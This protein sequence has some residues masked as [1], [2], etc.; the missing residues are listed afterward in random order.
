MSARVPLASR[1]TSVRSRLDISHVDSSAGCRNVVVMGKTDALDKQ[2]ND[3]PAVL[4]I[5]DDPENQNVYEVVLQDR[6]DVLLAANGDE[7]RTHLR[8][9][10]GRIVAVLMD[11]ALGGI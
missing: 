2:R 10:N 8:A 3:R 9:A 11:L 5:E 1:A 7:M 4:V 6:H